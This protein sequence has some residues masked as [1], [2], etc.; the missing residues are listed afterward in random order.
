MRCWW[1]LVA[2]G[3]AREQAGGD[4]GGALFLR[5]N[6]R[7]SGSLAMGRRGRRQNGG[8]DDRVSRRRGLARVGLRV[9]RGDRRHCHHPAVTEGAGVD[10]IS[11]PATRGSLPTAKGKTSAV[12][13]GCGKIPLTNILRTRRPKPAPPR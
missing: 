7:Q 9:F 2:G 10:V 12:G 11:L 5:Q 3:D 4:G 13:N 1:G 8:H 6:R